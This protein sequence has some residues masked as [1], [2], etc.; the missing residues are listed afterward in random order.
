MSAFVEAF[1]SLMLLE[2]VSEWGSLS[3]RIEGKALVRDAEQQR[4]SG[5]KQPVPFFKCGQR[6][7]QVLEH[8]ARNDEVESSRPERQISGIG[9]Y[10]W[11]HQL[12][13]DL[14]VVHA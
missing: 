14:C 3:F 7:R 10:V 1:A 9:D 8:M 11:R 4:T 5:G 12:A 6:E 13:A 2:Q